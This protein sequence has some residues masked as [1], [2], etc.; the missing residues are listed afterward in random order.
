ML[1]ALILM[2]CG[3]FALWRI[4]QLP[5]QPVR[6]AAATVVA[7]VPTQGRFQ[8]DREIIILRS[9]EGAGQFV[10]RDYEIRCHVGEI[11]P[12]QERGITL[13]PLPETCK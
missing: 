7:I 9:N 13:T 12:V 11:V 3:V 2:A 5:L 6:R 1:L 10:L 8:V 4:D